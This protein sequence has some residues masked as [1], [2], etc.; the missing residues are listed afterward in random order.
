MIGSC[1]FGGCPC[2]QDMRCAKTSINFRDRRQISA[3]AH[4]F[5]CCG[6]Q[7]L[8]PCIGEH[9]ARGLASDCELAHGCENGAQRRGDGQLGRNPH[10]LSGRA[11]RHRVSGAAEV[12]GVHHATVIRHI[13]ALGAGVGREA[14]PA[15]CARLHGDR[16]RQ[17]LLSVAGVADDQFTQL[18]GRIRGRG[19]EV[20]GDLIVTSLDALSPLLV[21][22]IAAFQERHPDLRV[23]LI[24][25]ARA[26]PAGIWA[27]RM[28]RSGPEKLPDQP[29][30]VVQPFFT[31]TCVLVAS[32][33]LCRETR[34]LDR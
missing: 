25:D 16:G 22:T 21:P 13:D 32:P 24:S 34:P 28:W 23:R 1:R 33:G 11:A 19:D 26:V 27:R 29:D 12:L 17:D 2:T 4:I 7:T 5:A 14:V 8:R 20:T 3:F 9:D 30:N 10:G 6:P 31:Q 15:P 18:A